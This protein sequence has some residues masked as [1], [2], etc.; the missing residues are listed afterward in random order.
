MVL[1]DMVKRYGTLVN[2]EC[3]VE[4]QLLLTLAKY[5]HNQY[6]LMMD[7]HIGL[8]RTPTSKLFKEMALLL[9]TIFN[10]R[11]KNLTEPSSTVL[12]FPQRDQLTPISSAKI[13]KL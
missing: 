1:I 13:F 4:D 2:I 9:C 10:D 6:Y 5:R 3:A 8:S 7:N 11:K 12:K